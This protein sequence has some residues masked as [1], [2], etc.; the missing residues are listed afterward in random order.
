MQPQPTSPAG[1]DRRPITWWWFLV[2]L[3][4][5]GMGTF[6]MVLVGGLKLR[7]RFHTVAAAGY[8]LLTVIFFVGAQFTTPGHVGVADAVI[9]PFFLVDWLGG[10]A[11][12]IVLQMKARGAAPVPVAAASWPTG[13]DPALAAAQW[14]AQRR[15]EARAL[16][17]TNPPLAA[18]LRIG[19]PDLPGRQYDDGGLVDVNH[20]PAGYLV[21]ELDLTPDAAAEIVAER[22]RRG[23]FSSPDE[24]VIFCSTM[25]PERLAIIRDR[26]VFIPV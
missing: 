26:L 20:V 24:L 13:T 25:T 6:V 8:F 5:C 7:S 9:T 2:P 19:R 21:S 16:L 23:G 14:R 12:V 10:T 17:T 15:Q 18:E 4:T 3:L 11:H 1:P 22:E